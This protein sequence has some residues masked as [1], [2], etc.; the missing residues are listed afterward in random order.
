MKARNKVT[1]IGA[2]NI[3][4]TIAHMVAQQEMADVVMVDVVQGMPQGKALDLFESAPIEGYDVKMLGTNTYE[5]TEDSDVIVIT[6]G[7]TRKPGMSRDDLLYKN[8]EIMADVVKKCAPLSKNAKIIVVSNPL[9]IMTYVAYKISGFIPNR[10]IGM[11]GVLDSARF[12]SFVANAANVSVSDV[13]SLVLGGHGDSMIPLIRYCTISGIPITNFLDA[14]KI[15]SISN[16]TRLAGGE[17]VNILKTSAYYSPAT[18]VVS[19]IKAI[20]CNKRRVITCAAHLSGEYGLDDLYIGVPVVLGRNGV[21]KVI[22]LEL[23][24][25][26]KKVLQTTADSIKAQIAKLSGF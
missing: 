2:G 18:S 26:E 22:E 7:M 16:R 4:S 11:A 12:S 8:A 10:V 23:E 5:E 15:K 9:D 25:G 17:I 3:G 13:S 1:I 14:A 20:L 6:A 19:M 21:E 24:D